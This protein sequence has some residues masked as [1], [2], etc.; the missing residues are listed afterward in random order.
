MSTTS[1]S[2]TLGPTAVVAGNGPS[3]S[4]VALRVTIPDD[5]LYEVVD[6]QIVEKEMGARDVEIA[7]ILFQN[8]GVFAHTNRLGRAL[9]EFVFRIDQ[10]RDLQR[11]PDVAFVSHAK[12]PVQLRVPDVGVWDMVPDLAVEVVSPSNTADQVQEKTHEYFKAGVG[13][14]WVVYPRQQ[15]I[16]VYSSLTQI[17]VLQLGQDLDG[18]DLVPGFRLPLAALFEDGAA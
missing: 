7:G 14:V 15:E 13:V 5:V 16:Y 3:A 12:W 11:R 9:M 8:L 17:R 4:S 6:G 2:A 18:G 10:G 1:T